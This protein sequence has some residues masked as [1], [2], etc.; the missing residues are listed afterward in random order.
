MI[1]PYGQAYGR[2]TNLGGTANLDEFEL[3]PQINDRFNLSYQKDVLGGV[4]LDLQYFFNYGTRV[5]FDKDL[6]MMDPAFKYEQKALLNTQVTNPFRNYLTADK[7]PGA[8]R[9]PATVTLGSLLKPYPQ[10][11]AMLQRNT[12]GK[13]TRTHTAEIRAQKPFTKGISFFAAYAWNNEKRQRSHC[14]TRSG[15]GCSWCAIGWESSRSTG[16]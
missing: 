8:L 1:E 15:S 16:P 13:K 6:N 5:P 7:F 3:R 4:V 10:Y 12:N 14:G 9:N 2:Y 11:S